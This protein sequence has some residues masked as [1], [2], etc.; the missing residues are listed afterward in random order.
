LIEQRRQIAE[1]V[2]DD[3]RLVPALLMDS[4]PWLVQRR[5]ALRDRLVL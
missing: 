4:S 2:A 1:G 5:R 3:K